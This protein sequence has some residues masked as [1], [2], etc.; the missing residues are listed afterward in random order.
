MIMTQ[1]PTFTPTSILRA[2]DG[3]DNTG[4]SR[5]SV[6]VRAPA[7]GGEGGGNRHKPE[8]GPAQKSTVLESDE[9]GHLVA[10][11]A[12]ED[13]DGD[14]TF[15]SIVEGDDEH[16][17][18]V[19]PDKGSVLLAKTLNWERKSEYDLVIEV[20]DGE[21]KV[22]T[23][24]NVAVVRISEERPRFAQPEYEVGILESAAVGT[25]IIKVSELTS[26]LK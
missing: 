6:K 5:V 21:F 14:R 17:F 4:L 20:T 22:R 9:V 26:P 25:K 1:I 16:A 18:Y 13:A 11:V 10:V 3:G 12:A 23:S 19:S 7:R 8:V 2:S 15:F 24:V